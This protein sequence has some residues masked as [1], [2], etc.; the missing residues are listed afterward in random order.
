MVF[1]VLLSIVSIFRLWLTSGLPL[2]VIGNAGH[3]DYLFIRLASNLAHTGWLGAFDR[4]TLIKGPFYPIFID[5]SS[6]SGIPLL[7]VEQYLYLFSGITLI[8]SIAPIIRNKIILFSLYILLIF[9]PISYDFT[10]AARINRDFVY[11]SLTLLLFSCTIALCIRITH[12]VKSFLPWAIG[13]G[14][15]LFAVWTIR[16]EGVWVLPLIGLFLGGSLGYLILLGQRHILAR[17]LIL[18]LPLL[19]W[20]GGVGAVSLANLLHY[21]VLAVTEMNDPTFIAAFASLTR[22]QSP[23]WYPD[24]PVT[25]E[26]RKLIYPLSPALRE[27]EPY[28]EGKVGQGWAAVG[29]GKLSKNNEVEIEGGW[30]I[31][32]FRDSVALAGYYS[33]GT[34]PAEYYQRLTNEINHACNAGQL[35]CYP[36]SHSLNQPID[37]RHIPLII[38]S[39]IRSAKFLFRFKHFYVTDQ[40]NSSGSGNYLVFEAMANQAV[41][42]DSEHPSSDAFRPNDFRSNHFKLDV[43]LSRIS[44][45]YGYL[46]PVLSL[47]AVIVFIGSCIRT[48]SQ[49]KISLPTVLMLGLWLEIAIRILLLAVIDATSFPAIITS[50]FAPAYPLITIVQFLAISVATGWVNDFFQ[51]KNHPLPQRSN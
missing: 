11:T 15:T 21:R 49:K 29:P 28:L 48:I 34:F 25:S 7:N 33:S 9:L 44:S 51:K 19:I 42:N 5:L 36:I 6:I 45:A 41:Q 10:I 1:W 14:L 8:L 50:Y 17:S 13:M 4:F 20:C 27:L 43:L 24:V 35:K 23:V 38:Q 32:A 39:T 18:G 30:N 22:V 31:W 3:D 2:F 26:A 12:P 16:E 40:Y 46:S 37:A 47:L